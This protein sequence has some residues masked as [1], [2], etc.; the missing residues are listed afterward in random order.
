MT[1]ILST[2]W[3]NTDVCADQYRCASTLYLLSVMLQ[4]YSIIVDHGISAPGHG[5][6]A[7]DG[8]NAIYKSYIYQLMS[9]VQLA[10]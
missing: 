4:F 2:I 9:N 3:E 6:E 5:K 7:V 1:S 10:G 8:M